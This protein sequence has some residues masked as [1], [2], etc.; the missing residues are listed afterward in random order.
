M[1]W[2]LFLLKKIVSRIFFFPVGISLCLGLAGFIWWRLRRASGAG[3]W[4]MFLALVWLLVW[5][6][7]VTGA[8]SLARLEAQAGPYA[9]PARLAAQGVRRVVVL[10]GGLRGG[11]RPFSDTLSSSAIYRLLE[12]IRLWKALPGARLVLTGGITY[13]QLSEAA[14]MR[15]AALGLGVPDSAIDLEERSRDT[16]DQARI[17]AGMV[18]A[19]PFALVTSA[20]HMPRALALCRARGLKPLPAPVDFHAL[21]SELGYYSFLPQAGGL[22]GSETVFYEG[23]G[24]LWSWLVAW[25]SPPPA[26]P[27]RAS[28]AGTR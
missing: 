18:G 17:L 12:G 11:Q 6:L 8:F 23:L 16:A 4:L 14:G 9:D 21:G 2:L 15:R 27:T 7:P 1:D 10:S 20:T 28:Q 5:S 19:E 22:G 25:W 24:R 26:Q 13:G 3:P